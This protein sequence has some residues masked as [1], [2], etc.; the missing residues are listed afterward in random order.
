MATT[1]KVV[2]K[3]TVASKATKK[4]TPKKTTKAAPAARKTTK[5]VDTTSFWQVK[6]TINTVYW[7]VIGAAVISTAVITYNTHV[8]LN[9][10]YDAI[11]AE[12][13]KTETL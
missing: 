5:A 11:D 13:A 10:L 1:K 3:K 7:L 6:F 9:N 8:Q 4:V 2:R 12:N